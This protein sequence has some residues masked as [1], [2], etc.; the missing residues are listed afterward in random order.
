[1]ETCHLAELPPAYSQS[2]CA[3]S[4]TQG[5]NGGFLYDDFARE[6]PVVPVA[7]HWQA[8]SVTA[9]QFKS[10]VYIAT[11]LAL[12]IFLVQLGTSLTDVPAIQLLESIICQQASLDSTMVMMLEN[13]C[14]SID[15]QAE[16][17]VISMGALVLGYLPGEL[18]LRILDIKTHAQGIWLTFALDQI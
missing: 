18:P 2:T 3:S 6:I 1:M 7:Q 10:P 8:R 5:N 9:A 17:N 4:K 12:V 15:V 14:W 16:L 13:Q 11:C